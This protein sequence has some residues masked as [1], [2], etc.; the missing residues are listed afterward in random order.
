MQFPALPDHVS[1]G[2]Q[3]NPIGMGDAIFCGFRTWSDYD[4]ILVVWG[5]QVFVSTQTLSR[6]IVALRS[7]PEN[8]VVLPVTHM[9]V[10]YVE[11]VIEGPRL[12][13]VLQTRE[14]DATTPNGI[15]DV[16]VFLLTTKALRQFWEQ[17]VEKTP[18]GEGTGE[19]NF[20]P[21]LPFLSSQGW[22]ITPLEV[23]DPTEA[24][25]INTKDDLVFFQRLY[26]ETR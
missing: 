26:N 12:L 18:R 2:I 7:L 8:H 9:Q 24:R 4:A 16:G 11:Y 17:Y 5:D 25:G 6:A 20:L 19:V 13:K 22:T 15:S 3:A 21:F 23:A 1:I 10:P 14:G